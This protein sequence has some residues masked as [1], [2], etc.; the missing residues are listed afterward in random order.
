MRWRSAAV[1]GARREDDLRTAGAHVGRV[2]DLVGVARLEHAVLVDA[3]S[4]GQT[5]WRPRSPCWP[6]RSCRVM[7]LT[8]LL[9]RV[10]SCVTISVCA[11]SSAPC[12]LMAMT[13]SSSAVLPRAL[14]QAVDGALHLRGA[15]AHRLDGKGR[16]HAEVVVR[17]D[18]DRHVL[19]AR[20]ALA[21]VLDA[22]AEG[23]RHVCSPWC[24]GCSPPWRPALTAR[25]HN[26]AEEVLV[27]AGQRPPHRT[28][29]RPQSC[30]RASQRGR[31]AL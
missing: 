22:R 14:A 28:R 2:D 27:G 15:V 6:A 16:R 23:P 19:D 30:A 29:R 31:R 13:T 20:H 8:S 1:A 24:R 17:V 5:R 11:S 12:I 4:C 10:S 25:L 26:A 21:Q 7:E 3:P 18:R 9:A